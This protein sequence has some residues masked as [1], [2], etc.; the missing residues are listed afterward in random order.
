MKQKTI[1][2]I[3]SFEGIGVHLGLPSCVTLKPALVNTGIIFV[4]SQCNNQ[5]M[6]VGK[7]IPEAAMHASVIKNDVWMVST[8]EHLM[9]AIS[10]FEIDNIE[11]E[12]NGLE[13]PILDGSSF[14]FVSKIKEIGIKEQNAEKTFITPKKELVFEDKEHDRMLKIIPATDAMLII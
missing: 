14:P 13:I 11:I 7:I 5:R 9:A 12:V 10:A 2:E 8:V 6:K 3:I 4:N 1:N